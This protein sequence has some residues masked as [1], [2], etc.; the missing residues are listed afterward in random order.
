MLSTKMQ[1]SFLHMLQ[2][3][4]KVFSGQGS[5]SCAAIRAILST[6]VGLN[7]G[8]EAVLVLLTN[9][10][11]EFVEGGAGQ[12]SQEAKQDAKLAGDATLALEVLSALRGCVMRNAVQLFG[13]ASPLCG[14][15]ALEL[16]QAANLQHGP[17]R[18]S[19]AALLFLLMKLNY[20]LKGNFTRMKLQVKNWGF[21]FC[22][23][24]FF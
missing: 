8:G 14:D 18:A 9:L 5:L 15:L 11:R 17:V 22:C 2:A 12:Q 19:A 6:V 7:C 24:F 16:L 13:R 23:H 20:S 10:L 21:F 3:C 4:L 1:E